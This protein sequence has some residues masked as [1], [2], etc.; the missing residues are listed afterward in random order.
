[1]WGTPIRRGGEMWATRRDIDDC[2]ARADHFGVDE[3][4][5]FK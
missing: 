5:V 3:K 4:K 2:V 1:M